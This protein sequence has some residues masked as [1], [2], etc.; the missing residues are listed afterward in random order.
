MGLAAQSAIPAD[1]TDFFHSD[2]GVELWQQWLLGGM[3]GTQVKE[4]CGTQVYEALIA[5]EL[6]LQE[7]ARKGTD[8][9]ADAV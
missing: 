5:S 2:V 4:I 6:V 7:A 9:Q 1:L 8:G 3:S